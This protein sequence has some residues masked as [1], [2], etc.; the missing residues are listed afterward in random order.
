MKKG[1]IDNCAKSIDRGKTVASFCMGTAETYKFISDNPS[2]E[3][4]PIDYTNSP[5]VIAQNENM[6]AINSALAIDLTGQA[7]AE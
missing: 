7:T 5:L 4:R 2:I 1:V 3:F 6:V